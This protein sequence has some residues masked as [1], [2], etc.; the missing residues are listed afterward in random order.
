MSGPLG[1]KLQRGGALEAEGYVEALHTLARRSFDQVVQR[2]GHHCF[3]ALRR[4]VDEAQ[5]GVARELGGRRVADDL[6]ERLAR[7]EL[8]V[9]VLQLGERAFQVEV[10]GGEN[11][12]SHRDEMRDKS[13]LHV[14]VAT[15][16]AE[17]LG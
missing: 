5:V 17:L 7:V 12:A 16:L 2:R 4:D 8:A 10:A 9:G 1:W 11:A 14:T 3:L 6:S 13:D 15:Q